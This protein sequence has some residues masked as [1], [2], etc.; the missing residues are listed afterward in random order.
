MSFAIVGGA[1][2]VGG[3]IFKGVKANKAQKKA[4]RKEKKARQEMDRL[5]DVY[6]SLDTS[7]PY[8]NMENTMEDL[9]INQKQYELESQQF[10][11]SQANILS[12]LGQAA[13]SSGIAAVAQ[14]LAQQGQVQAQQSAANIGAQER[15]NQMAERQMAANIQDKERQGEIISRQ[16]EMSKQGTLLGMQQDELAYQRQRAASAEQMKMDAISEGIGGVGS[17]LTGGLLGGGGGRR[18]GGGGRRGLSFPDGGTGEGISP[19]DGTWTYRA[20]GTLA[21]EG[22]SYTF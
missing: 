13:G 1:L 7:N 15:Q 18:G 16:Q 3:A 11:Q 19:G 21:K 17:M 8:L 22:A 6:A 10:Q 12:G 2:A 9:T 4:E 5:K 20:D 14:S